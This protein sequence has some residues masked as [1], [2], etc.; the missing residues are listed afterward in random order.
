MPAQDGPKKLDPTAAVIE[1]GRDV[2]KSPLEPTVSPD[3]PPLESLL[4]LIKRWN[5]DDAG[6]APTPFIERLQVFDYSDPEQRRISEIYRNAEVPFK[7]YNIPELDE[8]VKKWSDE[9]L[10][11]RFGARTDAH[12]EQSEDN[13]F[14]YW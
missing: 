5:P 9:Y 11:S 4:S 12:V 2:I 7:I 1:F 10:L 6:N 13:H 8:V 14:M 3:Y